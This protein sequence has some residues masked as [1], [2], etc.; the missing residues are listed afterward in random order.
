VS[1]APAKRTKILF[2]ENERA[3]LAALAWIVTRTGISTF[4]SGNLTSVLLGRELDQRGW[5]GRAQ[6][7]LCFTLAR[8]VPGTNLLACVAGIGW[9]VRGWPGAI[10]SVLALSIPASVIVVL[11]TVGY[12]AW[13]AHPLGKPAIE[14]AM[15]SIVGVIAASCWLLVKPQARSVKTIVLVLGALLLSRYVPPIWVMAV[16]ALAGYFWQEPM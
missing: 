13:H 11:L 14:A 5:L 16:A 3:P 15:A 8:A 7:D 2:G 9:W 4:G 12:Q 10:I 1:S 6:F